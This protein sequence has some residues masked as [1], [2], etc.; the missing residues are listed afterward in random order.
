MTSSIQHATGVFFLS[1]RIHGFSFIKISIFLFVCAAGVL[2]LMS[3]FLNYP[4]IP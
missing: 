3:D 4:L 2:S 1:Q